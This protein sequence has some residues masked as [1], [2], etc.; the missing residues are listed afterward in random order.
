MPKMEPEEFIAWV[1]PVAKGICSSYGLPASVCIA[2]AAIESGWGANVIGEYNLFGRKAVDGDPSL[3]VKTTEFYHGVET[4]IFD[5]FKLYA[6]LD[7]AI[8]DWCVLIT[9]EPRYAE[10]N[11]H[12]SNIDDFVRTLAPIYATNPGYADEILSI[13]NANDL[14]KFDA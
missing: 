14:T 2:Q 6:S 3:V 11:N 9:Q 5:N 8:E 4:S 1:G 10:V 12:L 13:I 7:E